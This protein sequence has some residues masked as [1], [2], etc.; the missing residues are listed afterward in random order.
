MAMCEL[1]WESLVVQW[2]IILIV[3]ACVALLR[4][5]HLSLAEIKY[6]KSVEKSELI[7]WL[8]TKKI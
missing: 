8:R 6:S 2:K 1:G 4:G 3:K 5:L 7:L